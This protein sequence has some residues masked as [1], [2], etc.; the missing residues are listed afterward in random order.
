MTTNTVE[1]KTQ[2]GSC[3]GGKKK[4]KKKKKTERRKEKEQLEE[5]ERRAKQPVEAK[6][7]RWGSQT[8]KS[9]ACT[10]QRETG[11]GKPSWLTTT[12]G[13]ERRGVVVVVEDGFLMGFYVINVFGLGLSS[14]HSQDGPGSA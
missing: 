6:E 9:L 13:C 7:R 12:G 4:K 10:P 1:V 5:R 8:S 2:G 11:A 3:R 14:Q